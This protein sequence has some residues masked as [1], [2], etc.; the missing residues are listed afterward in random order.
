MQV[1]LMWLGK[2]KRISLFKIRCLAIVTYTPLV[3]EI[4]MIMNSVLN[5]VSGVKCGL[6]SE[7]LKFSPEH[8]AGVKCGLGSEIL[9]ISPEHLVGNL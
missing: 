8:L 4:K 3:Y 9:Q 2:I 6:G 5:D 1:L 7:I